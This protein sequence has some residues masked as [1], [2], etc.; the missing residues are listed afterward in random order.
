[1]VKLAHM[2]S[3][4]EQL[5]KLPR[6]SGVYLFRDPNRHPLYVGKARNLCNR[7]RSYF[8]SAKQLGPSTRLMVSQIAQI[9]HFE[10]ASEIEAFLLEADLIKRLKPKYNQRLKDDKSYPLIHLTSDTC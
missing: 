1:M 3:V 10:T 7:V 4:E 2:K 9:E 6:S 8:H 5:A